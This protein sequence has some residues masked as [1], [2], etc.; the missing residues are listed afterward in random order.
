MLVVGL[1]EITEVAD[2]ALSEEHPLVAVEP[3]IPTEIEE[4]RNV[5]WCTCKRTSNPP[6]C[7]GTH[8]RL[9]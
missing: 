1:E 9:K 4:E 2:F 3:A 6:Y 7:D 5:A 8:A